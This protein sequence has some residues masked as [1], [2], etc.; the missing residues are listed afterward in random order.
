MTER[1]KSRIKSSQVVKKAASVNRGF[2]I[3]S[4]DTVV[5]ESFTDSMTLIALL[6]GTFGLTMKV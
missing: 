2:S 3:D 4:S 6:S 5:D 1:W